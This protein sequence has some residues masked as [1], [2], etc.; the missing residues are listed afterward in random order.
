MA[1]KKPE[2]IIAGLKELIG[3]RTDEAALNVL[4][5]IDDTLKDY[6]TNVNIE[7]KAKYEENDAAWKKKY[8][9]RFFGEPVPE[10]EPEEPEEK[11]LTFEELFKEE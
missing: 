3:D 9:D 4:E 6:S 11:K 10:D 7:W 5:D 8:K 2:E 1:I